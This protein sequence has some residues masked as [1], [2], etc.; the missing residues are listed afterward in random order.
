MMPFV[1]AV[2]DSR[3]AVIVIIAGDILCMFAGTSWRQDCRSC[4]SWV[5]TFLF[6][7]F[8]NGWIRTPRQFIYT[9]ASRHLI[10]T[11]SRYSIY[12]AVHSVAISCKHIAFERQRLGSR[13]DEHEASIWLDLLVLG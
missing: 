4:S 1:V 10:S 7:Q 8:K 13:L 12:P 11:A 3:K 2:R 5:P 9:T 6:V